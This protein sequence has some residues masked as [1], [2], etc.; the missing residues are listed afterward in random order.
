MIQPLPFDKLQEKLYIDPTDRMQ[1][2][3]SDAKRFLNTNVI[4]HCCNVAKLYAN[5]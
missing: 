1:M 2:F 3:S 4:P 5:L